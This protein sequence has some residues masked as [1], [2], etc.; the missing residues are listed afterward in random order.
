MKKAMSVSEQITKI[1]VSNGG[2]ADRC[3]TCCRPADAPY[4]RFS[5]STGEVTEGCV[6][7]VHEPHMALLSS[8]ATGAWHFRTGA[9]KLRAEEL[10]A[11]RGR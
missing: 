6:D 7:A 8:A 2:S 11:L 1:R 5:A 10:A 9:V 4:R 3:G